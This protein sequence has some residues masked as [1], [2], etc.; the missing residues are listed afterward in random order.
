M[1]IAAKSLPEGVGEPVDMLKGFR[2]NTPDERILENINSSIR[3]HL[4]QF[5]PQGDR[6]GAICIVGGGWS[7]DET[8][9]ELL[10]ICWKGS[11]IIA[12][13]GAAKWLMERNIRPAI[14]VVLDARPE[15]AEF[16]TDIPGCKYLIA[17]QCAPE[18]F[19][20]CEGKE[21]YIWHAA[22]S[23]E[24]DAAKIALL[25]E[26]YMG[27]WTN[28]IGGSTVGLRAITLAR[29]MG[30]KF[31]HLFGIDSCYSS[32]GRHHSYPQE[33]NDTEGS[34]RTYWA[35]TNQDRTEG[36]EFR[37][38]TWQASQAQHFRNWIAKNGTHFKLHIHGDGLLAYMLKTGAELAGD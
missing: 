32:D 7:L 37:C 21:T 25:D 34:G 27:H 24:E 10:D 4:P 6:P 3:R 23:D 30:F 20:A 16:I 2:V 26:F 38:S 12:L 15:N 36:R 18:T 11:S 33:L 31:Q 5:D 1:N 35:L 28:V 13:N 9:D 19:E 29:M 8:K 14:Q 22:G 17:S